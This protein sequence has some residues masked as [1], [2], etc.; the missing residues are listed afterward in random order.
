MYTYFLHLL[1]PIHSN[2]GIHLY[3]MFFDIEFG[4]QTNRLNMCRIAQTDTIFE[5]RTVHMNTI[6]DA[7]MRQNHVPFFHYHAIQL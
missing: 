6:L 2:K 3:K 5:R 4:Q 1:N 7:L